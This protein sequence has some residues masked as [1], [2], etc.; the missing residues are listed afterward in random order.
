VTA[1]LG[2]LNAISGPLIITTNQVGRFDD[3]MLR[4]LDIF[5]LFPQLGI[6]VTLQ[7]WE[8]LLNEIKYSMEQNCGRLL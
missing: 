2:A 6:H 3:A 7:N 8:K 4:Q 1:F 5:L